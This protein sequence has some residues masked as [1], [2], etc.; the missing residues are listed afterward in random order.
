MKKY[1]AICSFLLLAMLAC[2]DPA[3]QMQ[4]GQS[5]GEAKNVD[6][7]VALANQLKSKGKKGIPSLLAALSSVQPRDRWAVVEYGRVNICVAA[8]HELAG[9]GVYTVDEV[10]V[11]L[12]TI[13][14]Q[15]HMPDTFATAETLRIITGVDPG[16]SQEFVT[17]YSGS[18]ADEDI[19]TQKISQWERWLQKHGK[20][21]ETN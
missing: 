3:D 4:K 20:G 2:N 18:E 15:I 19:R 7:M 14:M 5:L 13:K 8:L 10:P 12:R 9:A 17:T 6:E 11:L 16:Y 1:F 21:A